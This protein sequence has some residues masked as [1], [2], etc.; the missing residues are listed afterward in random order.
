M[1]AWVQKENQLTEFAIGINGGENV[2]LVVIVTFLFL[3]VAE[4]EGDSK[5]ILVALKNLVGR[6][7]NVVK[8]CGQRYKKISLVLPSCNHPRPRI[9]TRQIC[10]SIDSFW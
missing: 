8:G 3:G 4:M 7:K 5:F 9:R 10:P 1:V 2:C 6:K